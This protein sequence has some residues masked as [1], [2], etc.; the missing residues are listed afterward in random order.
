MRQDSRLSRL[1]HV[2][3]H[4]EAHE[5]PITSDTIA[6]MVGSNAAL[7]RRMMAGLR[8]KGY[9]ASEKGHGGGW[10]LACPLSE[11]TLLDVYS[12]LDEPEI[13]AFGLSDSA[14]KCLVEQAVNSALDD[15]RRDARAR[16]LK[17]FSEVRLSDIAA[18]FQA[19]N[20]TRQQAA[21]HC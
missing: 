8:D 4:M 21:A 1:L 20:A 17:R 16:L 10:T 19:R 15:A 5:E 12:A 9:V 7:V 11:M 13:F 6:L 2:L 14:P 3:L 18:D